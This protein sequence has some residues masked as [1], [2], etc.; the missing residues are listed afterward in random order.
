[1]TGSEVSTRIVLVLAATLVV[2]ACERGP[3]PT[4]V[5][6]AQRVDIASVRPAQS[7]KARGSPPPLRVAVA[8]L[9]S[10]SRTLDAHHDLL[11]YIGR[12][13]GRP[14]QFFQ[15]GT[16]AEVNDLLKH[17]DIDLAFVCGG[18]LIAGERDF[19]MQV[20][21]VP[22]IRGKP[23]YYSYLVVNRRSGIERF[24]DLRGRSFAFSDPLSNS[25]R[26]APVHQL[27][28]RGE[29]PEHYFG[30][31]MFTYSH[32]NSILAVADGLVDAAAVD[33]LVY[34]YLRIRHPAAVGET[35]VI[36]RWGPY[37]TPPVVVNP[38]IAPALRSELSSLLLSM[39]AEPEGKA[40]LGRLLIDRFVEARPDLFR[41]I[42]DMEARVT[43]R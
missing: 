31:T 25:G 24:E 1:M 27:M 21:A 39:H 6:F 42:R 11:T 22:E 14:V 30:R 20:L 8:A 15:R 12:R 33:S 3:Q 41:S 2:A 19:G 9:L 23:A 28:L 10:P 17:R 4:R 18:A 43:G 35:R 38:E 40:I 16:Y 32:D 36:A 13:L 7:V 34:D 26:L 5:S 37:G 29:T